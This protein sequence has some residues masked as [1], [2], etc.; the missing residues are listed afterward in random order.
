MADACRRLYTHFH[1]C[2]CKTTKCNNQETKATNCKTLTGFCKNLYHY[3]FYSHPFL[4]FSLYLYLAFTISGDVGWHQ[5][6]VYR[7]NFN[8][9][10]PTNN[11]NKTSGKLDPNGSY[12]VCTFISLV[13]VLC[14]CFALFLFNLNDSFMHI[15]PHSQCINGNRYS[16]FFTC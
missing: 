16:S 3:S 14:S 6:P 11:E 15:A 1:L 2:S 5:Q 4:S 9:F 7:Y 13:L 12:D 8:R 10:P